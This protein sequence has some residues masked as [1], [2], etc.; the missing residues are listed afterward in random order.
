MYHMLREK[1]Q[2]VVW[3]NFALLYLHKWKEIVDLQ[4]ELSKQE[5][6]RQKTQIEQLTQSLAET[7][8]TLS[9]VSMTKF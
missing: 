2:T 5:R 7:R 9:S 1:I 3:P 8:N 6:A 4:L